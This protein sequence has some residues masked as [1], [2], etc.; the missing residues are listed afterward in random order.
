[1]NSSSANLKLSG[2]EAQLRSDRAV[3]DQIL[4][5]LT[6]AIMHMQIA[7]GAKISEAEVA[8]SFNASRTPVREAFA[9]LR[10]NGLVQ[11]WPSRGTFVT[12]LNVSSVKEARF[13]REALELAVV[14]KL[15]S[16]N[17]GSDHTEAVEAI[18]DQQE[19]CIQTGDLTEFQAL[20]DKFHFALASATGFENL[21]VAIEREKFKLDR[22]R[23]FSLKD[24][25]RKQALYLEHRA[26]FEA[27]CASNE[28]QAT[29]LMARH[30]AQILETLSAMA[31]QYE[32]YFET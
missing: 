5:V 7:P 22:L 32:E 20:D 24:K 17:L 12:K 9:R 2:S 16:T 23:V 1:M 11:T 19:Q 31:A 8:A 28:T 10:G 13:I 21:P 18:L 27:I 26:I 6:R 14:R 25:P 3:G 29:Q 15:C 4:D 30:L